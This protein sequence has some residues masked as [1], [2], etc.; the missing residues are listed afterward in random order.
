MGNSILGMLPT[1]CRGSRLDKGMDGVL[2]A[3]S[4]AVWEGRQ[5]DNHSLRPEE[6][7]Q[8]G[9]SPKSLIC[10]LSMANLG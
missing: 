10:E 4:D 5:K 6:R 1:T 7:R 2:P 3:L 8:I 9:L